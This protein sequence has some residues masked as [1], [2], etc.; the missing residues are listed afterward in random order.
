MPP[1]PSDKRRGTADP[2][3]LARWDKSPSL[4]TSDGGL[5]RVA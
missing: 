1:A 3:A 5:P 2:P 4:P